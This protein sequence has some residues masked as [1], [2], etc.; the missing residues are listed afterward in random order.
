MTD[1][2]LFPSDTPPKPERKANPLDEVFG[3]YRAAYLEVHGER[4]VIS[5]ADARQV[6]LLADE[7]GIQKVKA[8]VGV[9]VRL[10]DPYLRK[11]GYPLRLLSGSWNRITAVERQDAANDDGAIARTRAYLKWLREGR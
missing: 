7:F 8:R 6:K 9:F 1:G 5:P 2:D 4:P 11:E 10:D 3:A